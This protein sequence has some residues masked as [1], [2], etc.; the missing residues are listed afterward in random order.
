MAGMLNGKENGAGHRSEGNQ[1]PPVP[2]SGSETPV[3]TGEAWR[4]CP[5]GAVNRTKKCETDSAR[6][7]PP[8]P[9]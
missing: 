5:L 7:S 2:G 9:M 8:L 1:A 6:M 3:S 4:L